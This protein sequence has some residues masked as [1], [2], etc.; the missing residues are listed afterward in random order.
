MSVDIMRLLIFGIHFMLL[1]ATND[2]TPGE[3]Q[4]QSDDKLGIFSIEGLM[5]S[6]KKM[7]MFLQLL[8]TSSICRKSRGY[9]LL[10]LCR[11]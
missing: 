7:E 11:H 1:G 2:P 4:G 8:L 10:L 9:L 5:E 3:Q 6:A